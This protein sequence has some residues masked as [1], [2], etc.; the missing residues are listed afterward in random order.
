MTDGDGSRRHPVHKLVIYTH[1]PFPIPPS[2]STCLQSYSRAVSIIA[3]R[4]L[5]QA[6]HSLHRSLNFS[7]A[8]MSA[9]TSSSEFRQHEDTS[10]TV[11][12]MHLIQSRVHLKQADSAK[13]ITKPGV[14]KEKHKVVLIDLVKPH[15]MS[16][17]N[18]EMICHLFQAVIWMRDVVLDTPMQCDAFRRYFKDH[19]YQH[20]IL[21]KSPTNVGSL[22][23]DLANW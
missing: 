20:A 10:A 16:Q 3:Q 2:V 11:S 9:S 12:R 21:S 14:R 4:A 1:L 5:H 8:T 19:R 15:D 22:L 18:P 23:P 17:E 13:M 7:P 6:S